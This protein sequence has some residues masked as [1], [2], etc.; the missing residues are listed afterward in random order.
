MKSSILSLAAAFGLVVTLVASPALAGAGHGPQHGGV[1]REVK[2]VSYELVAKPD[3]LTLHVSDHGKPIS[4][5]GATAEAVIYAGNA[6]TAV[7][8]APAGGNRLV[9]KGSFRTGVGVR[10]A[11]TATLASKQAAKV[12]FNLK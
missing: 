5:E 8:L 12:T 6:K 1:A 2:G 7:T 9:A 4:T 3:S 10:V 11:V